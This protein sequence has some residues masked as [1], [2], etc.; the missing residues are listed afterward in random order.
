[1]YLGM[2]ELILDS[3]GAFVKRANGIAVALVRGE[4]SDRKHG[5]K[6]RID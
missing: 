2:E 6:A 3:R 1:M 4:R 5:W